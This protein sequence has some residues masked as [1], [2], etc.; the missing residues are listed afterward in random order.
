MFPQLLESHGKHP[1]ACYRNR[2]DP[3]KGDFDEQ[4]EYSTWCEYNS[5]IWLGSQEWEPQR[6]RVKKITGGEEPELL[7]T[8]SEYLCALGPRCLLCVYEGG[9]LL[10]EG[11]IMHSWMFSW[12][13]SNVSFFPTENKTRETWAVALYLVCLCELTDSSVPKDRLNVLAFSLPIN[14]SLLTD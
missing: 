10:G 9:Y 12:L 8:Y 5:T 7:L 11:Y 14:P 13:L 1:V 4:G 2:L 3:K 6:E